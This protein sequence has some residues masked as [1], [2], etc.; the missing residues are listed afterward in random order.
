MSVANVPV[1]ALWD[2]RGRDIGARNLGHPGAV[3]TGAWASSEARDQRAFALCRFGSRFRQVR[4]DHDAVTSADCSHA[5]R[6]EECDPGDSGRCA[7]PDLIV[8][9][10]FG[11]GTIVQFLPFHRSV[12]VVN[13]PMLELLW[14]VMPTAMQLVGLVHDTAASSARCLPVLNAPTNQERAR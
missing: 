11:L 3:V 1:P 14:D 12:S 4:C 7:G 2:T 6:R 10:A 5:Q 9:Y 13:G 8:R